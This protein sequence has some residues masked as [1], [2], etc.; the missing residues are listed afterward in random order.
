MKKFA[1][2]MIIAA[3]FLAGCATMDFP[4]E[5]IILMTPRGPVLVPK[6]SLN[7]DTYWTTDEY[8]AW[9]LEQTKRQ[10]QEEMRK[11]TF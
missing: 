2:M 9:L 1:V 3:M 4:P 6:H 11:R 7:P 5:D 10:M 8:Q